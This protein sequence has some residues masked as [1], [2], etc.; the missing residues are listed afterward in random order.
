MS[1]LM[2]GFCPEYFKAIGACVPITDLK[3]WIYQN[4]YYRVHVLACCDNDVDE[5][6]KGLQ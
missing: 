4:P 3:K 5:M 1:L 6:K 2:S